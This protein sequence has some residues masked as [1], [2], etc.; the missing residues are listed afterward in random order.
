L[1]ENNS[2]DQGYIEML[3]AQDENPAGVDPIILYTR[4]FLR[5]W[6][7][8]VH[9]HDMKLTFGLTNDVKEIHEIHGSFL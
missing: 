2:S 8:F 6:F 3:K 4:N 7:S 9:K 1:P 5:C